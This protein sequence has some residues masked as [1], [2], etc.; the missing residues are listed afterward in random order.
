[1]PAAASLRIPVFVPFWSLQPVL[2]C[3]WMNCKQPP[4]RF[5]AI[6]VAYLLVKFAN[7][8][9]F[10]RSLRVARVSPEKAKELLE[11]QQVAV[12]DLRH[13]MQR[14]SEPRTLPGAMSIGIDEIEERHEEIPRDRDVILF[15][16]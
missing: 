12:I 15:C 3:G 4:T 5:A 13:P 2:L 1:M 10:L 6:F 16:T 14:Q 11:T 8:Q 7:R 9:L